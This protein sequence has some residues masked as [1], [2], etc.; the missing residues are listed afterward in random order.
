[1]PLL[2][3]AA[4][5]FSCLLVAPSSTEASTDFCEVGYQRVQPAMAA[6]INISL[7]TVCA[8][9][10]G[11]WVRNDDQYSIWLVKNALNV[12][13][14]KPPKEAYFRQ[15]MG[16]LGVAG[17]AVFPFQRN[18]FFS[19]KPP[20]LALAPLEV[21]AAW[22]Q[23]EKAVAGQA[24]MPKD[25]VKSARKILTVIY[26]DIKTTPPRDVWP[27]KA[28]KWAAVVAW[29]CLRVPKLPC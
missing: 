23:W 7:L 16:E 4:F 22:K 26:D 11:F 12:D 9:A 15:A 29:V 17:Y 13:L 18:H 2:M 5:A 6:G 19:T 24:E 21:H 14:Y 25:G 1:M 28:A 3:V 27:P 8:N 10:T 20:V